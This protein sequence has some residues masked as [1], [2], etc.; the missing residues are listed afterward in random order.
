MWTGI[1]DMASIVITGASGFLGRALTARL[2]AL[3]LPYTAV[4]R[5][6]ER[7]CQRVAD[8]KDTPDG[9]VLIHLAEEPDRGI[10]N[11]L[12]EV[13]GEHAASLV[14]TLVKRAGRFVYASSGVVYGDA[15]DTPFSPDAEVAPTDF[16]SRSKV[17]NEALVLASGGTVLRLSN[18][19][20]TGMS[21]GNVISDI[22]RQLPRAGALKVRD[23]MPVRD[24]LN[25]NAVADAI[26][27]LVQVPCPGILNLGSG[28]GLSIRELAVL[29]LNSVGQQH[30]E[31]I[32]TQAT[33]RR[34]VN[35]LDIAETQRRLPWSPGPSPLVALGQF[36]FNR[37]NLDS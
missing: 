2:D 35:I 16:Y 11:S 12:G 26:A 4:S 19:F 27:L 25:V 8:Y 14:S 28:V 7:G 18:L 5:R 3:G 31:I 34:S 29:A 30:R 37:I 9:D 17:R 36:F 15:S 13:Y 10:V 24:F 23:D 22:A 21:P 6:S 32:V 1:F 33:A 20:G